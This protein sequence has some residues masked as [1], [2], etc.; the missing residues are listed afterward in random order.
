MPTFANVKADTVYYLLD[1]AKTPIN[2]RMWEIHQEY[3]SL[4]LYTIKCS[5]LQFNNQP[6]FVENLG[7]SEEIINE[8]KFKTIALLTL[9]SLIEKAKQLTSNYDL[10]K[11]YPL[12]LVE[13][14]SKKYIIHRVRLIRPSKPNTAITKDYIILPVDDT[15]VKKN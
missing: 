10:N 13:R 12:F 11:R 15:R 6:I 5:C 1:T 8:E 9:P 4:K 3:P 7:N 14:Q 2:D